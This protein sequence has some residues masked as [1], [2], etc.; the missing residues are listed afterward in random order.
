MVF[1]NFLGRI[2]QSSFL[3]F[4]TFD[5]NNALE[6]YLFDMKREFSHLICKQFPR[7]SIDV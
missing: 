2:F 5:V 6:A 4:A 1:V 7:C 3:L